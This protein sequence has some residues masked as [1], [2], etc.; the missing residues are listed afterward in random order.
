MEDTI[1]HILG[2][3]LQLGIH[4]AALLASR[5]IKTFAAVALAGSGDDPLDSIIHNP[6]KPIDRTATSPVGRPARAPLG[7]DSI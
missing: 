3:S 7:L 4:S 1:D 5:E 6:L 2:R